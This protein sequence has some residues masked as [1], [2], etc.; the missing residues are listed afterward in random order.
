MMGRALA[1]CACLALAMTSPATA[2]EPAPPADAP[3]AARPLPPGGA[4]PPQRHPTV[5]EL[6]Q[7]TWDWNLELM[8]G[9]VF[10]PG[11]AD[12]PG[13]FAARMR[14]GLLLV[15]GPYF[16]Q[17]GATAE[18]STWRGHPPSFGA[19][20]ELLHFT[21]G[22]WAAVG[23]FVDTDVRG[24]MSIGGGWTLLGFETQFRTEIDAPVEWAAL[25]KVRV[26][27]RM[28]FDLF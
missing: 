13:T 26:P 3:A 19:Q 5:E 7:T 16:W 10:V 4:A 1:A 6:N 15:R 11:R 12:N 22:F 21:S 9:P 27:L 8:F 2:Q 24:G 18:V 20:I 23:G 25:I 14:G 28:F 17:I